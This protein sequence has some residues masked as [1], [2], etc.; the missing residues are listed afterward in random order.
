[1]RLCFR[2]IIWVFFWGVSGYFFS[3][4]N[5]ISPSLVHGNRELFSSRILIIS[6]KT[7]FGIN[8][9]SRYQVNL[10][11]VVQGTLHNSTH[12]WEVLMVVFIVEAQYMYMYVT[13]NYKVPCNNFILAFKATMK[14]F[15]HMHRWPDVSRLSPKLLLVHIPVLSVPGYTPFTLSWHT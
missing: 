13:N 4:M 10:L 15:A 12:C 14:V 3:V 1:M 6:D 2:E 7:L 5:L 11:K 8:L 9:L